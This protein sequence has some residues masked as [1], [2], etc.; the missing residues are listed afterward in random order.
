MCLPW[1]DVWLKFAG[2]SGWRRSTFPEISTRQ[3]RRFR[4]GNAGLGTLHAER[5]LIAFLSF[6]IRSLSERIAIR[7]CRS[8]D[9][10]GEKCALLHTYLLKICVRGCI[11]LQKGEMPIAP[12]AAG[13][14][15]VHGGEP[16]SICRALNK[17]S[18]FASIQSAI[19][20]ELAH[21]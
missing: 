14:A 5:R 4:R 13:T 11:L 3:P 8:I 16:A 15:S 1:S 17:S 12:L 19:N 2:E 6:P 20:R 7:A 9:E 21:Q 10:T 18:A